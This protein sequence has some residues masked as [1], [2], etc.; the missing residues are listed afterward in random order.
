[1]GLY[2]C[3]FVGHSDGEKQNRFTTFCRSNSWQQTNYFI[4]IFLSITPNRGLFLFTNLWCKKK[5]MKISQKYLKNE[6]N[7]Y[8]NE[9]RKFPKKFPNFVIKRTNTKIVPETKQ[10][11]KLQIWTITI[12][13][14]ASIITLMATKLFHYILVDQ[15]DANTLFHS[16][17][18]IQ[19]NRIHH[20]RV[21]LLGDRP[22]VGLVNVWPMPWLPPM[23]LYFNC[24]STK[25]SFVFFELW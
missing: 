11:K 6:S 22:S 25:Y 3:L 7:F 2:D 17:T 16:P 24:W 21:G 8:T 10:K 18:G 12:F 14:I 9:L 20:S 15:L 4:T 13:F 19:E 23:L 5:L 1:L